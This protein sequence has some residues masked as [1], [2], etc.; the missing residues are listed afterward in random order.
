MRYA[1]GYCLSCD[2]YRKIQCKSV[3]HLLHIFLC[4]F[5]IGAWI[6]IYLILV[7]CESGWRG[8]WVCSECGSKAIHEK[9]KKLINWKRSEESDY[10]EQ[11]GMIEE[12]ST[13]AI[14]ETNNSVTEQEYELKK[15][16]DMFEK[17]L[18]TEE[19]KN[20]MRNKVLG[21]G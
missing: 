10:T 8:S 17:S 13:S 2:D 6:F 3:S 11:Y 19:E 9:R 5:T 20:Q 21:L 1:R 4:L 16:D 18:I 14:S 15:I 7:I 12:K